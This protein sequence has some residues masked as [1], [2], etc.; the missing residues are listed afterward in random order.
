MLPESELTSNKPSGVN[1]TTPVKDTFGKAPN[2]STLAEHLSTGGPS[3]KNVFGAHSDASFKTELASINGQVVGVPKEIAPGIFEYQ[4]NT[5]DRIAA[6]K[7]SM[8]KTTYD[9]RYTDAQILDMSKQASSQVWSEI[10][11]TGNTLKSGDRLT[12]KINGVP[13]VINVGTDKVTGSLTLYAH[14]G[15]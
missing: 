12:K 13:F 6:G 9:T 3:T 7:P 10:Q 4:Y 11:T 2:D 1:A 8:P 14:P 15:R 5:P